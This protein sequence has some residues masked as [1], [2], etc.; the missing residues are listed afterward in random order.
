MHCM[1]GQAQTI[2]DQIFYSGVFCNLCFFLQ[3][4]DMSSLQA[5]LPDPQ[6]PAAFLGGLPQ[7]WL[8]QNS[9]T[10]FVPPVAQGKFP[11]CF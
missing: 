2:V 3:F 4:L 5:A 1:I 10:T 6:L 11:K 8:Q 9:L 7:P